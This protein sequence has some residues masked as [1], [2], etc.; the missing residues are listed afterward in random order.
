[1]TLEVLK[2]AGAATVGAVLASV[3]NLPVVV[4]I[5][6]I[7]AVQIRHG[8]ATML[9]VEAGLAVLSVI[10]Y[11]LLAVLWR[12]AAKTFTTATATA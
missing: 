10:T 8:S 12:P 2:P 4:G 5:M 11:S 6:F 9:L 1:M 3:S 7:G